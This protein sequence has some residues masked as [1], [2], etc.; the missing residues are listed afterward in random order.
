MDA[1]AVED[2]LAKMC[3]AIGTRPRPGETIR[4]EAGGYSIS[5]IGERGSVY[6]SSPEPSLDAFLYSQVRSYGFGVRHEPEQ[7]E[8]DVRRIQ[9]AR[10]LEV[11]GQLNPEWAKRREAEQQRELDEKP[12]DDFRI[13]RREYAYELWLFQK[14]PD[15][16]AKRLAGEKYPKP[17]PRKP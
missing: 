6:W 9:F 16:E 12:F 2:L 10:E 8:L 17:V 7:E 14:I 11:L 3:S 1:K 4:V 15:A 13:R 5:E